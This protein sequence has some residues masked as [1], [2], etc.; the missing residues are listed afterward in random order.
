MFPPRAQSFKGKGCAV[1]HHMRPNSFRKWIVSNKISQCKAET[2]LGDLH[3][4]HSWTLGSVRRERAS[5][6]L[7]EKDSKVSI[8]DGMVV[9]FH[10]E[11]YH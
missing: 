7:P 8:C 1:A 11:L 6:L 3:F 10:V 2:N 5:G 4:Q 9:D